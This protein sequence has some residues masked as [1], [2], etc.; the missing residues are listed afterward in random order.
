MWPF[1]SGIKHLPPEQLER[2][3]KKLRSERK[4]YQSCV[5][6][7]GGDATNCQQLEVVLRLSSF[8]PA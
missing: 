4:A 8:A 7:N 5:K 2:L 3:R 6:A 1:S